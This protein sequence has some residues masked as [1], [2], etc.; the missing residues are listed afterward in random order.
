MFLSV[1]K[2]SSYSGYQTF[3]V[4][5][6]SPRDQPLLTAYKHI[7]LLSKQFLH[8]HHSNICREK[9]CS[10]SW[11]RNTNKMQQ[12]RCLLSNQM[13]NI[14]MFQASLCPSSGEKDHVL[15]HMGLF[16]GSVGCG[17]LRCCGATL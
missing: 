8:H 9:P 12:Y 16:A 3:Q 13:F 5:Q 1:R 4:K 10:T 15:L 2:R 17:W 7:L 11:R 6:W 14:D